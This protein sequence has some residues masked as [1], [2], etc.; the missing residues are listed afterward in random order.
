MEMF[1]NV[2]PVLGIIALIFAGVLAARVNKQSAGTERMREIASSIS[3][4]PRHSLRQSI[5]Y[6]YSLC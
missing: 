3:E 2:V 6:W 5:K 1:L 4:G